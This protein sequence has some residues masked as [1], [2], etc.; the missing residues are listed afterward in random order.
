MSDKV[1]VNNGGMGLASILTIIF[2]IAKLTGYVSWSWW[3]VFSPV[4][5]SFGLLIALL[6]G[7]LAL[8]AV[9]VFFGGR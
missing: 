2:V 1:E 8:A 9:A 6:A 4:L 3:V 7:V 5:V